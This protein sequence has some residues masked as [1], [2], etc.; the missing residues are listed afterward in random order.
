MRRRRRRLA[1]VRYSIL[2]L[3]L[4]RNHKASITTGALHP[5]LCLIGDLVRGVK[6]KEE[7][8]G[9]SPL[10]PRL[11]CSFRKGGMLTSRAHLAP[12]LK[13]ISPP[14]LSFPQQH[15]PSATSFIHR[16]IS[17]DRGLQSTSTQLRL[18]PLL[19]PIDFEDISPSTPSS[20][21]HLVHRRCWIQPPGASINSDASVRLAAADYPST[22]SIA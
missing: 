5:V 12:L 9:S 19:Q 3:P 22:A 14:Q 2:I 17:I 20:S 1:F 15:L 8:G 11:I 10:A 13:S 21:R 7:L 4:R 16:N 6:S 18:V